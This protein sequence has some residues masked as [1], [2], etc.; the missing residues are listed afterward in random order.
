MVSALDLAKRALV[1]Q[2]KRL[3]LSLLKSK[4]AQTVAKATWR[5]LKSVSKEV[6]LQEGRHGPFARSSLLVNV[7]RTRRQKIRIRRRK[8]I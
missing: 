6:V 2:L 3:A 4:R 1:K 5:A 8:V 7:E